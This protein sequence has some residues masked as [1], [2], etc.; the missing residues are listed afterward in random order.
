MR[1]ALIAVFALFVGAW[2]L[3]GCGTA[4]DDFQAG[5][6]LLVTRV[7]DAGGSTSPVFMAV[8]ETDDSGPDGDPDTTDDN[9]PGFPDP[10]EEILT[11][12][13]DDTGVVSL[14]NE[15][16]PGVE[17]GVELV[18]F[19]VDLTYVD[20]FGRS[21]DFAP[22]RSEFPT[23]EVPSGGT[24]DVNVT[25][26]PVEMKENG[27]RDVF[28]FGTADEQEAVREWTVYVDVY[29]R[30]ALNDDTV[31]AGGSITVRFVNPLVEGVPE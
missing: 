12:L 1:R 28:L 29:A 31:H 27:L 11:P 2:G 10:G 26:V 24:A 6:R 18:V 13:G 4:G 15:P 16:R 5:N 22:T 9:N 3:S 17:E 25:L 7:A 30:D 20:K 23:V 8:E 21:H 14:R 19:R